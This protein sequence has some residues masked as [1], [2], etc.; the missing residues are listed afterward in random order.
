MSKMSAIRIHQAG[1]AEVMQLEQLAVPAPGPKQVLVNV[2]A[3]GINFIDIYI[4]SGVYA[5]PLPATLGLEGAGIVEAV[6]HEVSAL[7][8]GDRVAWADIPGS[9]ATHVIASADRLVPLP[10]ALS[11]EQ[12]A[13]AMLQGMTVHYLTHGAYWLKKGDSCLVHAAAGGVGLLLCQMGKLL[14]ARVIGTVSTPEKAKLA[15]AAGADEVILYTQ[16]D[17]VPAIKKLTDGHGVNVVYDSVGKDTLEKSLEVLTVR[18]SL[19]SFGQSSGPVPLFNLQKLSEKSLFL[20]RPKLFDY[21]AVREE[22]LAR[23]QAVFDWIM[24]GKMQLHIGHTY[25][26]AQ[27]A[28]AHQDLEG[29]KTTGKILLIPAS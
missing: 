14:G 29:R 11:F 28:Q 7:K 4:R 17:F 26:L 19:I 8:P 2:K 1:A 20:T 16:E 12:G 15:R 13:A 27:A 24:T 21:I 22:L 18:G 6:G 3:I 5:R 10:N 23:S 9:Y 25:P